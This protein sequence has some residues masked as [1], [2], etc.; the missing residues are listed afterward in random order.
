M[1]LSGRR[2]STSLRTRPGWCLT[3][4]PKLYSGTA[5]RHHPGR[6]R[7]LVEMRRPETVGE[8][9]KFLQ[10]TNWMRLSMPHMAETVAPLRALMEHRLKGTSRTKSV[11]SR[12]ALTDGVWTPERVE[13]WDNS[14]EMLMNAIE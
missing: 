7:R 4:V 2:I 9:M 6:V 14:R 3:A 5:V 13:A 10:V 8:L 1:R 11:A 12:R